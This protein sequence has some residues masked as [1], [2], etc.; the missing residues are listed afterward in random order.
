MKGLTESD[1][2]T[3]VVIEDEIVVD[4]TPTR[5]ARAGGVPSS[6]PTVRR[7]PLRHRL[8]LPPQS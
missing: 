8:G 5:T 4:T 2:E 7:W 6:S 1:T 3:I